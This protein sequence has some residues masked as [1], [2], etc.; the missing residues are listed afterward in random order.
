MFW[1]KTPVVSSTNVVEPLA[2]KTLT[3]ILQPVELGAPAGLNP[4]MY[5]LLPGLNCSEFALD[6][7]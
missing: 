4:N 1:S 7:K 2:S 6:N 5:T 3:W